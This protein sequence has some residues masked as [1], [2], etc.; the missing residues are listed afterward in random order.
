VEVAHHYNNDMDSSIPHI[1]VSDVSENNGEK[2]EIIISQATG[3][4]SLEGEAA[5]SVLCTRGG[6]FLLVIRL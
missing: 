5:L 2:T 1:Y 6:Y 4:N 3:L